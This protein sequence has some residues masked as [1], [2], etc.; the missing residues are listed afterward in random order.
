MMTNK[1]VKSEMLR[2]IKNNRI[3]YLI[4][5]EQACYLF[6]KPD[7]YKNY[8][9]DIIYRNEFKGKYLENK[10][11]LLHRADNDTDLYNCYIMRII[12]GIPYPWFSNDGFKNLCFVIHEEK[13]LYTRNLFNQVRDEYI[14]TLRQ[15]KENDEK[16][17]ELAKIKLNKIKAQ[18][19]AV[20]ASEYE[21]QR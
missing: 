18:L 3:E 11:F 9:T 10:Y 7:M 19:E 13:T 14:N 2:I 15:K 4:S 5:L 17:I 16:E 21:Y 8:S 1:D 6:D 20:E 12:N